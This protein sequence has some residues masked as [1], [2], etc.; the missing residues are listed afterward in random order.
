MNWKAASFV[1][2]GVLAPTLILAAI[3]VPIA[4]FGGPV[5]SAVA[6]VALLAALFLVVAKAACQ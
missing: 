5:G 6:A 4:L 3:A 2:A 1:C